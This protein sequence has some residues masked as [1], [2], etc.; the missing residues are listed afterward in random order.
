MATTKQAKRRAAIYTR[1]S[2]DR[3]DEAEGV[4]RQR[5]E[6][7]NHAAAEGFEIMG[8]FEDNDRSAMHGSRP[9]Y[10]AMLAAVGRGEVEVVLVLRT[11]RLYRRL[12]EL[13]PLTE[14]LSKHG[15]P[16]IG[17]KSGEV[18][19]AT[20][21]GRLRANIMGAV[22]QHESEVKGERIGDAAAD[23][24]R[25][26]RFS[27][28]QRRFGYRHR[29]VRTVI[30]RPRGGG[31][32]VDV[33]RP[34][35]PLVLVP[36]EAD[37]IAWAYQHILRGGS[38]ES[39]VR[40]WRRR[41]LTGPQGAEFTATAMRDCLLRPPNAGLVFYKGVELPGRSEMPSIVEPDVWRAVRAML[42][43]PSRRAKVGR[44]ALSLLAPVLRCGVCGGKMSAASKPRRGRDSPIDLIYRCR[45]IGDKVNGLTGTHTQRIRHKLDAGIEELVVQHLM[46]NVER[47][48]RPLSAVSGAVSAAAQE[49]DKLRSRLA[50]F[51][52]IASDMEPADYVAATRSIRSKLATLESKILTA[53]GTPATAAL[54]RSDD[55]ATEWAGMTVDEKRAVIVEQVDRVEVGRGTSGNTSATMVNVQ[56]FWRGD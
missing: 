16:V 34:T 18:D 7:E 45:A 29:D 10:E 14:V 56:L 40:E 41:G 42:L 2:E 23:R 35:G 36:E 12:T 47:L 9:G 17:V 51:Q 27:G 33:E 52:A 3:F 15:V 38:Q 11:D 19:L 46:I 28:G 13:I 37:A 50:G 25:R 5:L 32:P 26:G 24:I 20:A 31:E 6:C 54:V 48:R 8:Y 49:A 22:S 53:V 44:P 30:V 1:I 39:V 21:D 55:L 43:D 4:D